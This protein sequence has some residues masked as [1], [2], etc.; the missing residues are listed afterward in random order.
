VRKIRETLRQQGTL[1]FACHL[2]ILFERFIFGAK[3]LGKPGEFLS[4]ALL[5]SDVTGNAECSDD[6]ALRIAQRHLCCR[7]PGV[8]SIGPGL[9]FFVVD[10]RFTGAD[11]LAFIRQGALCV[12]GGKQVSIGQA[13]QLRGTL[14]AVDFGQ[15]LANRDQ[16]AVEMCPMQT[17]C[18]FE[19]RSI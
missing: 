10:D 14:S 4:G 9:L 6:I 8:F 16:A 19:T 5:F 1:K 18:W 7:D 11:Y 12:Q 13:D 2:K 15:G 17:L 3:L